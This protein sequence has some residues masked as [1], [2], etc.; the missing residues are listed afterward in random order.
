M[1][2]AT[3]RALGLENQ[4]A[5]VLANEGYRVHQNPTG[6]EVADARGRSG[7]IGNPSKTPDYLIEGHV[8]DCYSPTPPKPVRGIWTEVSK[9]IDKSQTQRVVLNLQDWR[10]D[11]AALRKQF[12]DWPIA[13]LKEVAAVTRSG[14]II[15]IV[16]RHGGEAR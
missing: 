11:L 5:D 9:K 3:R 8:F 6:R 10:G 7:D 12:D 1:D 15:Q 13:G 2:E 14:A 16:P 4:C